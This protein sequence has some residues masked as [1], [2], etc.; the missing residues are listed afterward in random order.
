M[1][2]LSFILLVGLL[3]CSNN[4]DLKIG[5]CFTTN[6]RTLKWEQPYFLNG[7]IFRVTEIDGD[8]FHAVHKNSSG[9]W[10]YNNDSILD[11]FSRWDDIKLVDCNGV[12]K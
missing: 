4:K 1:K 7:V 10:V 8:Y 2:Y 11:K 6:V 12:S 5:D 3:S 9:D